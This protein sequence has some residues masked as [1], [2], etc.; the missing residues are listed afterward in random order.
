MTD[1]PDV[2][3]LL[4]QIC[5]VRSGTVKVELARRIAA[6]LTRL[7]A[8]NRTYAEAH[9]FNSERFAEMLSERDAAKAEIA[10]LRGLL[11]PFANAVTIHGKRISAELAVLKPDTGE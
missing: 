11:E 8:E 6:E 4:V 1:K 2:A 9:T 3:T 7:A 10:R 5:S